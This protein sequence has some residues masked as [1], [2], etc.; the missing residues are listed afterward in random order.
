MR[1]NAFSNPFRKMAKRTYNFKNISYKHVDEMADQELRLTYKAL[2]KH[3]E[4]G[5]LNDV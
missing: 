3:F 5:A 4:R 1:F 2:R